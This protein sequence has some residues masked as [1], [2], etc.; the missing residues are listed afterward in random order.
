VNYKCDV[1]NDDVDDVDN[2]ANNV[3]HDNG[4]E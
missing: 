3:I 2:D 1:G 4:L